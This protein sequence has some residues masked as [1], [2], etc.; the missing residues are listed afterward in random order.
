MD[1]PGENEPACFHEAG[2]N[3]PVCGNI[4]LTITNAE[5]HIQTGKGRLAFPGV[6]GKDPV[7]DPA[8]GDQIF[9]LVKRY[10]VLSCKYHP[11]SPAGAIPG[12]F[13]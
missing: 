10:A 8:A 13:Q 1:L 6:A 3:R 11:V 5:A 4:L 12:F 7:I 2:D 9:K